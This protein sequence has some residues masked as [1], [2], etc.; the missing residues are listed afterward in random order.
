VRIDHRRGHV[1][2]AKELLDRADVMA[3]LEEMGGER[4][5]EGMTRDP[6]LQASL[7]AGTLYRALKDTLMKVMTPLHTIRILP[8]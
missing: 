5:S 6:L 3:A 8:T 1:T 2:V 7:T 4:M